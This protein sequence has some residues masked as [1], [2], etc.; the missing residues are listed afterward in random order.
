MFLKQ[1]L[2]LAFA[3]GMLLVEVAPR[4]WAPQTLGH[5]RRAKHPDLGEIPVPA[6]HGFINIPGTFKFEY[7]NNSQGLRDSR[8]IRD[9]NRYKH[10]ILAL[11]DSFTYGIG[12]DDNQTW[13]QKLEQLLNQPD[14]AVINAGNEGTG[15]DYALRFL[16]LNAL[17]Y[18][19]DQVIL[20]FHFSD[21]ENN[22]NSPIYTIDELGDFTLKTIRVNRWKQFLALNPIYNWL[23]THVHLVALFKF[24]ILDWTHPPVN[25]AFGGVS[26]PDLY[27]PLPPQMI[28]NTR[29]YLQRMKEVA[30]A[31]KVPLKV[32]YTPSME[33]FEACKLGKKTN[34]Q[35]AF[36]DLALELHLDFATLTDPLAC[37]GFAIQEVYL[38]DGHWTVLGHRLAAFQ[39]KRKLSVFSE[40][41]VVA[42][43]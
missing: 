35:Q 18:K 12:V 15:T 16:E 9:F 8:E 29:A 19:P 24:A 20:A 10:R 4:C 11:G 1:D 27:R 42:S 37:S 13:T 3:L 30:K 31:H 6:R 21:F 43:W 41:K 38:P 7:V 40:E 36:E 5:S 22:L 32:F 39:V 2:L 25:Q 23:T 14:V 34:R 33:D 17:R 26:F 28:T